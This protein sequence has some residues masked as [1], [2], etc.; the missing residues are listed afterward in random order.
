VQQSQRLLHAWAA[1]AAEAPLVLL[2]WL[3]CVD[4]RQGAQEGAVNR[5]S[6]LVATKPC[7]C[8]HLIS[9]LSVHLAHP[10]YS[11]LSSWFAALTKYS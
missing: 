2:V 7:F 9:C 4:T 3:A 11:E 8:V 6:R 5:C 10:E 1:G